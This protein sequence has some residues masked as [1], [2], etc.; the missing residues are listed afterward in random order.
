VTVELTES[1]NEERTQLTKAVQTE[2]APAERAESFGDRQF[3]ATFIETAI[4]LGFIAFLAYWTYFLIRPFLPVMVWSA[5]LAAALYPVFNWLAA[6]LGGRRGLAAALITI[7]LLFVVI[8]PVTWLGLGLVDGLKALLER[9]HSG[10]VIP[11]PPEAIKEWPLIGQQL[12]DYWTHASAN[13][14]EALANLLPQLQ[15]VGQ[16]LLDTV[17][18]AG[19]W[20][21]TFLVSVIIAGFLFSPAPQI[22]A[23]LKRV[24]L[25]IDPTRGEEFLELSGATVRAVSRGV[26]GLSL[27]QSVAAGLV[28]SL[29][30]APY[31]SLLTLGILVLGIVQVGT[32]II[33]APLIVWSWM[34]MT[35]GGALTFTACMLMVGIMDN[36]KPFFLGRG[37]ATPK[38]VTLIGVIGGVLAYGMEGLCI[39]PVVLAVAWDLANAWIHD[40]TARAA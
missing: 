39:G 34:T 2:L 32:L 22:V 27:L 6:V 37:L 30:G 11:P 40:S 1:A 17:S 5:V 29:A 28:L 31:A 38:L 4:H 19:M 14:R 13:V 3:G 23:A 25:R 8:G 21:L 10:K 16:Y 24:A 26:I 9:F 12:F 33:V 15:P 18:S 20:M 36:L 7:V 35:T